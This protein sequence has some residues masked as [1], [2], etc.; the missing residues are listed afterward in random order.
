M[1]LIACEPLICREKV[2]ESAK[3]KLKNFLR[4]CIVLEGKPHN[5][6]KQLSNIDS[7]TLLHNWLFIL[8]DTTWIVLNFKWWFSLK[9]Y[10]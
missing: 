3:R 6:I 10:F 9:D 7:G 8:S 1:Y 2:K 4:K 5:S